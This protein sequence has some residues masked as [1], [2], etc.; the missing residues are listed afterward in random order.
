[1]I[2]I[3]AYFTQ[4]I[5]QKSANEPTLYV[6]SR[7]NDFLVVCLYVGDVIYSGTSVRMI[8][9]FKKSMLLTFEMSDF[10]FFALSFGLRSCARYEW[11]F[12]LSKKLCS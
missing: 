10:G 3:D 8:E 5:F 9:E 1:M 6:K 11:V 12:Y 2:K 7:G 4:N